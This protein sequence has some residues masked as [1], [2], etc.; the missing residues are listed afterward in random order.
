[1][2]ND[3]AA[4]TING[5]DDEPWVFATVRPGSSASVTENA[6]ETGAVKK[7]A[8]PPSVLV[9]CCD[10]LICRLFDELILIIL[11]PTRI[12]LFGLGPL[13]KML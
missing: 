3:E 13:R 11:I 9:L 1:M 12:V 4:G 10:K 2:Y 7:F 8:S 6:I 5:E